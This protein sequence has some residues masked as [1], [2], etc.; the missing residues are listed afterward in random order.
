MND[1]PR[2]DFLAALSLANLSFIVLW[3]ALLNYTPAQSF[4]LEYA[5]PR[6]EYA[7][8][9]ASVILTGLAFFLLIRAAR[10]IATRYGT[11]GV[12]WGTVPILAVIALPPAKSIV[13]LLQNRFEDVDLSLVA[14]AFAFLLAAVALIAR[15]RFFQFASAFL[16]MLS[17][18]V[19]IEAVLSVSR[20]SS[21]SSAAFAD[22]PYAPR[23]PHTPRPRIVWII[24]D[25]LDYRLAFPDRASS[26]AM[27]TFDRL[28]AGS[29]FAELAVSPAPDTMP[30]VPSLI[31]GVPFHEIEAQGP[32]TALWDGVSASARPTIFSRVHAQGGNAAIVGWYIPYCRLYAH[33]LV[34]CSSH[35][36]ESELNEAGSSF[37]DSVS[38]QLQ[39]LFAYGYRSVLGE[40]PRAQ[41]H[42]AMMD[43]IHR[44]ALRDAADPSLDLVF[45]HLPVPHAPYLYDRASASFPKRYLGT[46]T[47]LDN[48]ALADAYLRDLRDAIITAGLWDATTVVVSSDHPDRSSV[49]VDGKEDPRVPFLLKLAGQRAGVTYSPL[50]HTIVTK[51]LLEAILDGDIHTSEDAVKWLTAHPK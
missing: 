31:T 18:L 19:L 48:L 8:A 17:P 41:H 20:F 4:Y 37:L 28:R 10:W 33:D 2:G 3:D 9:F 45:L 43:S 42:L 11:A 6:R 50:L 7:A 44:D 38:L 1:N 21:D 15:R 34:A 27:P 49:S 5:P 32:R 22:G 25:E 12:I 29:L 40:S 23:I 24:F 51:P 35:D 46:G 26:L 13:R 16:A 14:G 39:S 47:Y 30:S 36:L